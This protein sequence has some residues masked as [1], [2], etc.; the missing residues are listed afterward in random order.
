VYTAAGKLKNWLDGVS[1][2]EA[3]RALA[4]YKAAMG[5]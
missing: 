4:E 1:Q 2:E 5:I 3:D